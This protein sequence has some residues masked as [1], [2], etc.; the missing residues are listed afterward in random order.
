MPKTKPLTEDKPA[1]VPVEPVNLG[2]RPSK[3][4]SGFCARVLELGKDG[5]SKIQIAA[6]LGVNRQTL[7]NWSDRYPEF[8]A[9]LS[10]AIELS[11]AWWEDRGQEGI[12]SREFNA[13]AY[14]LQMMNRFGW[15]EKQASDNTHRG[16]AFAD[17]WAAISSGAIKS[18]TGKAG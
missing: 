10:D 15:Q 5:K 8:A 17:I 2:G 9:A 13:N 6:A 4:D 1:L 18:A 11:Q 7:D 16:D 12:T 14:R 3:Y